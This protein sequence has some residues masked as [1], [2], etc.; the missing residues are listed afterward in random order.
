MPVKIV[1]GYPYNHCGWWLV[2]SKTNC[3]YHWVNF[4]IVLVE[5]LPTTFVNRASISY[6]S[7]HN[8][9]HLSA[10]SSNALLGS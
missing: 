8:Y 6:T 9:I 3:I 4:G 7:D 5:K 10:L 2:E 1:S